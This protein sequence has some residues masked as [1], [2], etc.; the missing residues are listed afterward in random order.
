MPWSSAPGTTPPDAREV[1]VD[2]GLNDRVYVVTGA[3]GGVGRA[4]AEQLVAEGARLVLS[5]DDEE[6][7][8]KVAAALGGADRAIAI[9]GDLA[10]PG[11]ETCL[12]AAA[13]A[14]Y[15]RLDGAL[16]DVSP[17][18]RAT[19]LQA[20]DGEWRLGFESAFLAP[21][22]LVRTVAGNLSQ[23]GGS[24][25]LLLSA[26]P[27]GPV[28]GT[29]V[30]DG[31]QPA[32]ARAA[33]SLADE[34]GPRAVRVNSLVSGRMEPDTLAAARAHESRNTEEPD[35]ANLAPASIPLQRCG[36]PLE[37]A[38]PAVFLLSPAASYV[39]GTALAVDGGGGY[40]L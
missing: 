27:R 13:I 11:L 28:E 21:L 15:G 38:R 3:A 14:R 16:V 31:L 34:L 9:G 10:D 20:D 4:C 8:T 26:S 39:T 32:L 30:A 29:A 33:K 17:Q 12:V 22:R 37:F 19:A 7:L 23:E 25:V 1:R 36:E 5:G 6:T 24:I 2:L 35:D 40:G 18:P